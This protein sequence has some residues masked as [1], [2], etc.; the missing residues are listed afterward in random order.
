MLL[1]QR[2]SVIPDYPT[3]LAALLQGRNLHIAFRHGC[4]IA[5]FG[6]KT[7]FCKKLQEIPAAHRRIDVWW[8]NDASSRLMLLLAFLM[9]RSSEWEGAVIRLLAVTRD[10]SDPVE[11]RQLQ[12]LLEEVRIDAEPEV[13]VDVDESKVAAFSAESSF[14]FLPFRMR[15]NQMVTPFG[16]NPDMLLARLPATVLVLTAEDID[17]DETPEEGQAGE[18]AAILDAFEDAKKRVHQT[19]KDAQKAEEKLSAAKAKLMTLVKEDTTDSERL[20]EIK[21]QVTKAGELVEKAARKAAKARGKLKMAVQEAEAKGI[22][23]KDE[24]VGNDSRKG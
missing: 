16:N 17:L 24:K 12:E 5:V 21:S 10:S 8:W 19:E 9:T 14:V 2:P 15:G 6:F 7:E 3:A 20:N 1:L 23:I 18:M 4:N 13:V 11:T 22:S